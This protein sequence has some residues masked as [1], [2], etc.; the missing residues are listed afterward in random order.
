MFLK[1]GGKHSTKQHTQQSHTRTSSRAL[2]TRHDE[3]RNFYRHK[4]QEKYLIHT[5]SF[6]TSTVRGDKIVAD[7]FNVLDFLMNAFYQGFLFRG[8]S[9]KEEHDKINQAV[10]GLA[11]SKPLIVYKEG[12]R[13][14]D[15]GATRQVAKQHRKG[16]VSGISTSMKLGVGISFANYLPKK[17]HAVYVLDR[18]N[19]PSSQQVT[20]DYE[21][22]IAV[23]DSTGEA[24]NYGYERELTVSGVHLSAIPMRITREGLKFNVECNPFYVDRMVLPKELNKEYDDLLN[25]FYDVIYDVRRNNVDFSV[26]TSPD[27]NKLDQF[28]AKEKEFYKKYIKTV[29]LDPH[30]KQAI[31]TVLGVA[32]LA[33]EE[34]EKQDEIMKPKGM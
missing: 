28:K 3:N 20:Q 17:T 4:K 21:D 6:N 33:I 26:V 31:K 27:Q 32:S 12:S 16:D 1:S 13:E 2:W 15:V 14:I 23:T 30:Q 25:T 34:L 9:V 19:I 29:D 24:Q 5:H 11:G 10:H 7:E 18:N 8:M 22:D